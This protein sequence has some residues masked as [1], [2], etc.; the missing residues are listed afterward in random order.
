MAY[1]DF[2]RAKRDISAVFVAVMEGYTTS[3]GLNLIQS[4]SRAIRATE[5]HEL[6][7]TDDAGAGPSC[8]V[9]RIS[10]VGFIEVTL[11]GVLKFGDQ[12][13]VG[14][15]TI[16]V[17][18]GFD[19]THFPNHMNILLQGAELRDGLSLGLEPGDQIVFVMVGHGH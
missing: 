13:R 6:M 17:V 8:T 3:R 11:G 14:E 18:A 16:G 12:A 2:I 7:L 4:G 15:R 10:H 9:D 1:R 5:I 19:L